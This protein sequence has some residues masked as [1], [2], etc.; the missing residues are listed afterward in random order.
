MTP[1]FER[2]FEGVGAKSILCGCGRTHVAQDCAPEQIDGDART[3][4]EV[5]ACDSVYAKLIAENPYVVGCPCEGIERFER[6]LWAERNRI[7]R[8]LRER[9]QSEAAAALGAAIELDKVLPE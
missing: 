6:L 4:Y 2:I 9:A 3:S 5:H 1:A 8:Y 7:A